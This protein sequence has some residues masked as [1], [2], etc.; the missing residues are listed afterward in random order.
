MHPSWRD[1]VIEALAAD[2]D[3]AP[4]LP[5]ALRRRRR[6]GRARRR[7]RR[8]GRARAAAAAR[9]RRLGRARRRPAPPL[10]RPRRGRGGAAA[11]RARRRRRGRRGRARWPSSCCAAWA[12]AARPSA[13]TRSAP[14]RAVSKWLDPRPTPPAVAMTWLE[15]EPHQRAARRRR[16]S[17]GWPT[18]CAWP[19]CSPSARRS[20]STGS[21]SRSATSDILRALRR[22]LTARRAAARARAAD[23]VARARW[24]TS[25]RSSPSRRWDRVDRARLRD[26]RRRRARRAADGRASRSTGC[27]ATSRAREQLLHAPDLDALIGVDVAGEDADLGLARRRRPP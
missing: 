2:A 27:C 6:R 20:C 3:R 8:G 13:S 15:L 9:R 16:R 11:R 7:R 19:S 5:L 21:A 22:Q 25:T 1:L 12:G 18:G 10:R 23:R 14:G 24:P 4:A 26:A 17:S